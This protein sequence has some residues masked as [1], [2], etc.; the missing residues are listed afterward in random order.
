[1]TNYLLDTKR[2]NCI[3]C[4]SDCFYNWILIWGIG[5]HFRARNNQ[6]AGPLSISYNTNT[7]ERR[8][9]GASP[10]YGA[11]FAP[12]ALDLPVRLDSNDKESEDNVGCSVGSHSNAGLSPVVLLEEW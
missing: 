10:K 1:M 4:I 11:M 2:S 12:I 9:G 6:L 5:L 8:S 3:I 7:G